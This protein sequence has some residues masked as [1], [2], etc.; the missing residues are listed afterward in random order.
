MP[1]S[2]EIEALL[3]LHEIDTKIARL[4]SQRELLPLSLRRIEAHLQQHRQLLEEK[5]GRIKQL[6]AQ[7]HA[8][9]VDLRTVE[10][11]AE[12][13]TV[14]LNSARTNKE[15]N[16]LQQEIA[17]RKADASRIEDDLLAMMGDVEELEADAR[18][19]ERSIAQLE[20]Q[21]AD[22]AAAVASG[23]ADIDGQVA[24]LR[25][26][27]AAACAGV[28]PALLEEY[29]RIAAKKGASALAPVVGESCQGCFM[30]LPP[31]FVHS[32]RGSRKTVRCP[33]CSR[34]LYMP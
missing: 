11:E 6:R 30:Q 29:E 27:R 28:E 14:Q 22:E 19:R 15:Y 9:E 25:K 31:Q 1:N 21:Q 7:I 16:A 17:A 13:L 4:D 33:S 23:T 5:R 3:K 2:P 20:R 32:L 24:K 12:K 10:A 8:R 26:A 34:I 18:D